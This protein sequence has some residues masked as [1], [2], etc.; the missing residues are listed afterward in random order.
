MANVD[1]SRPLVVIADDD[2]NLVALMKHRFSQWGYRA[3]GA[4]DKSE[5]LHLVGRD[6]PSLLLLDLRFGEHDGLEVLG[7]LRK[8]QPGLP[9]IMFT[10]FGSIE[11]AISAIKMGAADYVT[12]P[13]DLNRLRVLAT[14]VISESEIGKVQHVAR[15]EPVARCRSLLG[16]SPEMD[17]VRSLI[18]KVA[19]TDAS[20]LILGE[21]GTG[22]ELVARAIHEQSRRKNGPFIPLNM[23]ALPRELVESTLFGHERGAFTG[24]DQLQKGCCELADGGTLFLDEIGEM[25]VGLQA[26]LLRFLQE[27]SLTRVGSSHTLHVD[28]RV[29]AATNR[30]PLEQVR[31]GLLREDLYYRLKVVPIVVPPL[32]E[33]R[34]DIPIL[35]Q[36]FLS[37]AIARHHR[38]PMQLA[39]EA[40]DILQNYDWPGNVRELEH[41]IEQL[42]ILGSNTVI[43]PDDIP[44]EIL[45][46]RG[47]S[48]ALGSRFAMDD[49]ERAAII[50]ALDKSRGNVKEAA[51]LLGIG[52]ATVY[53]KIKRFNIPLED[54]R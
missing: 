36:T 27:R 53:R 33:R 32:R 13:P 6:R 29:L 1:S 18:A 21:S 31:R 4:L 44:D 15:T 49:V 9:V 24:A 48:A 46:A 19:P 30:D 3:Q 5:L 26:K 38:P 50:A 52:Y 22:K 10:G 34:M 45:Q 28:V 37:L 41:L 11:S 8:Q 20:V 43:A 54:R 12:K 16:M 47:E 35:A 14:Q 2:P 7:Q 42:V 51:R 40:I 25:E 17:Q 39:D 23:A